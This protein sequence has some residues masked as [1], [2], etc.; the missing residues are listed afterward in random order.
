MY[1]LERTLSVV[2][3]LRVFPVRTIEPWPGIV[4]WTPLIDDGLVPVAEGSHL[5]KLAKKLVPVML[6]VRVI[7]AAVAYDAEP[8]SVAVTEQSPAPT[9]VIR[10]GLTELS[11]V[12]TLGELD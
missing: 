8:G 3:P 1:A 12:Q 6:N 7:V 2:Q 10:D 9:G 5:L 11:T 4:I